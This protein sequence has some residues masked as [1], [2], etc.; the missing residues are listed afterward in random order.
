[1]PIL[2]LAQQD[3]PT[4]LVSCDNSIGN[5]CDF[6]ALMALIN[7]IINFI[8]YDMVI[9]IAAIMF[10]YAGF[11]YLTSA[12]DT[13]KMKQ[14]HTIFTNAAVGFI[15]VLAAWLIITLILDAL[16][17]KEGTGECTG[18]LRKLLKEKIFDAF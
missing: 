5:L 6:N 15:F 13:G 7:K 2:S 16:V 9:P 12:G 18:A 3:P 8:L 1:M 11:L 4:G 14:A 10:A 17:C